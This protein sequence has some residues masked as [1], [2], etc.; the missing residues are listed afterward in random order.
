MK[1]VLTSLSILLCFGAQAQ[2]APA[3]DSTIQINLPIN[4]YRALLF[5]IDANIDSKKVSKELL[6]FLQ[7]NA[8]LLT[9]PADPADKPK[10]TTTPKKN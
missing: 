1:K 10:A 3:K 8:K 4:Q 6:E 7:Q 2:T 9:P 5:T